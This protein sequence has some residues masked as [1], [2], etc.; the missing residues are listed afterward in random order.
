[1]LIRPHVIA[2]DDG[3]V[4]RESGIVLPENAVR[5]NTAATGAIKALGTGFDRNAW[6][7][8]LPVMYNKWAA[9]QVDDENVLVH[10]R[11]LVASYRVGYRNDGHYVPFG[12]YV[13]LLPLPIVEATTAAGIL[14]TE[15]YRDAMNRQGFDPATKEANQ[16]NVGKVLE[17]HG[18]VP[19]GAWVI[20]SYRFAVY[21]TATL[22]ATETVFV[23]HDGH[24]IL[25]VMPEDV[26]HREYGEGALTLGNYELRHPVTGE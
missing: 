8:G 25:A 15:T 3:L 12:K 23:P 20:F 1:V 2:S 14:L 18:D 5:R 11:D 4:T 22:G 26:V 9:V 13:H 19:D 17:G 21:Y 24:T 6:W 16:F 7:A 10:R